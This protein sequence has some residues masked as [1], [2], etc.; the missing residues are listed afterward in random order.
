M[1][2]Q[3]I[4]A[5]VNNR[6]LD[7][8]YARTG[9]EE[10]RE[11]RFIICRNDPPEKVEIPAG[12]SGQFRM[13]KS[14]GNFVVRDMTK[15]ALE[16]GTV[17]FTVAISDQMVNVQGTGYYDIRLSGGGYLYTA[18]GKF[19]VD[20]A[21]ISSSVLED[22]SEVNGLVFPDDF[23]TT[24]DHVAII[25]DDSI[26][27]DSTWSSNKINEEIEA[28][29]GGDVSKT[30]SGNPI[31]FD[32][33][34]SAPLVKCVTEIQGSQD[35]H[36]YDK[37]WVGGAGKNKL[38]LVLSDIK[39]LNTVGTWSGDAYT[40]NGVTFTIE[41]D[42]DD[43]ITGIKAN[44][45][46]SSNASFILEKPYY[47]PDGFLSGCPSGG[48]WEGTYGLG[49]QILASPYTVCPDSGDG[50]K[51]TSKQIGNQC[52]AL[53]MIR[54][55][56]NAN[57]VFHPQVEIGSSA[58][59]FEP[60]S[61]ICS[62]TAYT[63]GEIEVSDG[64]GNVTTHTTTYPSAIYRGSED[65]VE[66]TVG[67]NGDGEE[68]VKEVFDG[69]SDETWVYNSSNNAFYFIGALNN[70]YI[71]NAQNNFAIC[72]MAEQLR[73]N[74]VSGSE[75]VDGK[76][77]IGDSGTSNVLYFKNTNYS[78]VSDFKTWL[79][80]N[81]LEITYRLATPTT[82]SVTPTNLPIKSLSGYNHIESSTGDMEVEYI[83]QRFQPL[84]DSIK[85]L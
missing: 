47:P 19:I 58:T 78:T 28:H 37:P 59:D 16:D 44:G 53:I 34:A 27:T 60:Y 20:S 43:N 12:V 49:V 83:T 42:G 31:T 41:T 18:S 84:I 77:C 4:W 74:A 24:E 33:G 38:P 76:F 14:S 85:Q 21:V 3:V 23:L 66:G 68:W 29:A 54:A 32:D 55:N 15:T 2:T 13:V 75:M 71:N 57:L 40:V 50:A 64:D 48:D 56:Y 67:A 22:V 10:I 73:Y 1:I 36:G 69:S 65:C 7:T 45:T 35:L 46:P 52:Q 39:A 51:L 70:P 26:S 11:I 79:S 6:E 17:I 63:E 9:D 5:D 61:N 72:N 80:T 81:N 30:V 25:D 82:S 62:I 8:V